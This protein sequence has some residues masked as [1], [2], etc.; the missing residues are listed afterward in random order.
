ML[1]GSS[2]TVDLFGLKLRKIK[3]L[4][5][6]RNGLATLVE[7]QN[8][9][10]YVLKT[11]YISGFDSVGEEEYAINKKLGRAYGYQKKIPTP[12]QNTGQN[13]SCNALL[14]NYFEAFEKNGFAGFV[15]QKGK[16]LLKALRMV[17][18]L[19]AMLNKGICQYDGKPDNFVCY[20]QNGDFDV[21]IIDFGNAKIINPQSLSQRKINEKPIIDGFLSFAFSNHDGES[22]LDPRDSDKFEG[23][24]SFAAAKQ[25]I[26][27]LLRI[28]NQANPQVQMQNRYAAR[29]VNPQVVQPVQCRALPRVVQAVPGVQATP[30]EQPMRRIQAAPRPQ[31]SIDP[32]VYLE[33]CI[34]NGLQLGARHA[35]RDGA[36]MTP[37]LGMIVNNDAY[38]RNNPK[39]TKLMNDL[40][41]IRHAN[42]QRIRQRR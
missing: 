14:L 15:S 13:R 25:R 24:T 17:E 30:R 41:Y 26:N 22:V 9:K 35:L 6:G 42:R 12:F 39:M 28:E 8:R 7:D 21:N 23:V 4:G 27:Y 20:E 16:N 18:A 11:S 36:K 34:K 5:I 10:K 32:Q 38:Q 33:R 37:E 1:N 29:H 31:R 3:E 19:E 2:E 40:G